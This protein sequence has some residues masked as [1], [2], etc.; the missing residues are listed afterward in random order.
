M[1][2]QSDRLA[3]LRSSAEMAQHLYEVTRHFPLPDRQEIAEELIDRAHRRGAIDDTT[4][5]TLH[6]T[7]AETLPRPFL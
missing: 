5:A 1:R 3:P 4:A 6:Q 2:T 7:F